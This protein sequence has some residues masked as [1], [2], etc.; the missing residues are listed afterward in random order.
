MQIINIVV[1]VAF[2]LIQTSLSDQKERKIILVL[3][4]TFCSDNGESYLMKCCVDHTIFAIYCR[5]ER[6]RRD[7]WIGLG[8]GILGCVWGWVFSAFVLFLFRTL[9]LNTSQMMPVYVSILTSL[10]QHQR[11]RSGFTDVFLSLYCVHFPFRHWE[12]KVMFPT[13]SILFY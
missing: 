8:L 12:N 2:L 7:N 3:Y 4:Q 13:E 5:K 10:L 11:N 1:N 9:L 6:N